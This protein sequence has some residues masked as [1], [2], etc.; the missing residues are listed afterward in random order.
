M[1]ILTQA[2]FEAKEVKIIPIK[3]DLH[4]QQFAVALGQNGILKKHK[5]AVPA[6]LLVLKGEINFIMEGEEIVLS[7]MDVYEIPV[8]KEHEVVGVLQQNLFLITKTL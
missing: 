8:E 6:T 1:N 7:E 3:K 2:T 4:L 5:T